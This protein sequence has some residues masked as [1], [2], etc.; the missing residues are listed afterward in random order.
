MRF[1]FGAQM[2]LQL[3]T[4]FLQQADGKAVVGIGVG[5]DAALAFGDEQLVEHPPDRLARY[6]GAGALPARWVVFSDLHV[7]QQSLPT[8]LAVLRR[9]SAEAAA[10]DA[11]VICLGDFWH[12]GALLSTRQLNAVLAE[13][14]SW[15]ADGAGPPVLMIPGNHDQAMRGNPAPEL[16]ALTPLAAALPDNLAVFSSPTLVGN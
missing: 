4:Q 10:R 7:R 3:E 1:P 13:L 14:S 16:H 12:A 11:G 5:E 2:A 8:C 6:D 15:C 9:V